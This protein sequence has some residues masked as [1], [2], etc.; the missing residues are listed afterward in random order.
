MFIQR[1][2]V[3]MRVL[4]GL[5][6]SHPCRLYINL[7]SGYNVAALS[8]PDDIFY[9][10]LTEDSTFDAKG[11]YPCGLADMNSVVRIFRPSHFHGTAD[12]RSSLSKRMR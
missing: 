8:K 12:T 7:L 2:G 10:R 1:G 11:K 9:H 4:T 5:N 6:A 3:I